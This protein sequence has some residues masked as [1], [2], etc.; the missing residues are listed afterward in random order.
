[1][2]KEFEE[3][4]L[5]FRFDDRWNA[6]HLDEEADYRNRIARVLPG[7]K[8][9][10]FVGYDKESR[11]L[12]MME[13]KSFRGY[14]RQDSVQKRL[15]GTADDITLEIAQKVKDSL[16]VIAGGARN[17]TILAEEWKR[18]MEHVV[19]GGTLKIVAWIEVDESTEVMLARAKMNMSTRRKM[20][21]NRL[22]W[23]TSNVEIFNVKSNGDMMA[24]LDVG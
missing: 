19:C 14:G 20:L 11:L 15:L 24:G 18:Y 2:K 10:D 9:V 17:S 1:M 4:G 3:S 7:T 6:W 22:K 12:L 16:A 23:L 13:V 8:C 21:R 5:T